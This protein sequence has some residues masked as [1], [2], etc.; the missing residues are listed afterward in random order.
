[1]SSV[2]RGF[3]L[4]LLL[5]LLLLLLLRRPTTSSVAM[6]LLSLSLGLEGTHVLITGAGGY[7]GM[8]FASLQV[9]PF[10]AL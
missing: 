8:S 1:M 4:C 10:V 7:I 5:L 3:S 6:E 2:F 9:N